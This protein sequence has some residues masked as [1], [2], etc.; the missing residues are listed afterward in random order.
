MAQGTAKLPVFL[1]SVFPTRTYLPC[2]V[3]QP[4]GSC[5]PRGTEEI[6]AALVGLI[7]P[8]ACHVA[9]LSRRH[10]FLLSVSFSAPY[11]IQDMVTH[12]KKE[13]GG[14]E[15]TDEGILYRAGRNPV[16]YPQIMKL[17]SPALGRRCEFERGCWDCLA[18]PQ[19]L[20]WLTS[21]PSDTSLSTA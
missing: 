13:E 7:P 11:Q 8:L 18:L 16:F 15:R 20:P 14:K 1:S 19:P 2:M 10:F 4:V 3:W 21:S 17:H 5:P 9:P 12:L 6:P